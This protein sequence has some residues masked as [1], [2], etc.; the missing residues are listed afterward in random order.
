MS[1][2]T[3]QQL[4]AAIDE[5]RRRCVPRIPWWQVALQA[6]LT[7]NALRQMARGTASDRTRARAAAWLAR[8]TA[9]APGPVTTTAK[10]N[11]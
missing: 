11:H 10:D 9:P 2:P 8:H 3:P 5:L 1:Q 4:H 7:E 6:D